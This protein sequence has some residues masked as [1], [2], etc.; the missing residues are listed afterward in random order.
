MKTFTSVMI[1][2]LLSLCHYVDRL[3]QKQENS[4]PPQ[5]NNKLLS[6]VEYQENEIDNL[7]KDS[8]YYTHQNKKEID[9]YSAVN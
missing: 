8:I 9:I 4:L 1:I 3:S 2:I 5:S 6:P 7:R